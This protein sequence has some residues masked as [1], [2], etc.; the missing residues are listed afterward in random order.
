METSPPSHAAPTELEGLR[1]W[2]CYQH[3]APTALSRF[4]VNPALKF[5]S[6]KDVRAV[7]IVNEIEV[8]GL[9]EDER[10]QSG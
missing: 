10:N 3:V 4:S 5:A 6:P 9:E 1:R 2:I 8:R 7:V